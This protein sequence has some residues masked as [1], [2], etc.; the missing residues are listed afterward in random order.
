MQVFA[1]DA[2]VNASRF[3]ANLINILLPIG[4]VDEV[5]RI[6]ARHLGPLVCLLA[7]SLVSDLLC[8]PLAHADFVVRA[9]ERLDNFWLLTERLVPIKH[10]GNL[11]V[12]EVYGVE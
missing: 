5:N 9:F 4:V 7:Q 8:L 1:C 11:L 3:L 6:T 2:A 12:G 10:P